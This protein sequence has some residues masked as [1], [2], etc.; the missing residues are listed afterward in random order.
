MNQKIYNK[1]NLILL[2][3]LYKLFINILLFIYYL[4]ILFIN[5]KNI[6]IYK[7]KVKDI[8]FYLTT[9]IDTF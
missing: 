3:L 9:T 5:K 6:Y 7:E 8:I 2:L 1:K 4:Y